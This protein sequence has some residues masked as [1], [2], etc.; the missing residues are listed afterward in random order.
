MT[1]FHCCI[2]PGKIARHVLSFQAAANLQLAAHA[3]LSSWSMN[4]KDCVTS[5]LRSSRLPSQA[6]FLQLELCLRVFEL[7]R[8]PFGPI[9]QAYYATPCD[10]GAECTNTKSKPAWNEVPSDHWHCAC[11]SAPKQARRD[12]EELLLQ[13]SQQGQGFHSAKN[14]RHCGGHFYTGSRS[15][16]AGSS[17]QAMR[18]ATAELQACIHFGIGPACLTF[19]PSSPF[20]RMSAGGSVS[21]EAHHN[22]CSPLKRLLAKLDPIR[23]A[24]SWEALCKGQAT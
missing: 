8:E 5:S 14:R 21:P 13:E 2:D 9:G 10:T 4:V 19:G 11:C 20:L 7:R 15:L 24:E 17:P 12:L 18:D 3:G 23:Q 22:G 6:A 16:Q 1:A